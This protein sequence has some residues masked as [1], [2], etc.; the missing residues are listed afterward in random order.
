MLEEVMA[1]AR[2][3]R[4]QRR[5]AGRRSAGRRSKSSP[6]KMQRGGSAVDIGCVSRR[7][8]SIVWNATLGIGGNG[9][10]A[11]L[12]TPNR[13]A[14]S[15]R[16]CVVASRTTPS[17]TRRCE[18]CSPVPPD[19]STCCAASREKG[20]SVSPRE[21]GRRPRERHRVLDA[22]GRPQC[23]CGCGATSG[24]RREAI[25]DTA[26]AGGARS[27]GRASMLTCSNPVNP[28]DSRS[29]R[30]GVVRCAR[31]DSVRRRLCG[32]ES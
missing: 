13:R 16:C 5:S 28:D 10:F 11:P 27:V 3:L 26:G 29:T 18:L 31:G 6:K 21:R 23:D 19:R 25:D 9:G 14:S 17:S 2:V 32:G 24:L 4:I 1:R 7:R 30:P 22:D 15:T 12:A 20:D 8:V